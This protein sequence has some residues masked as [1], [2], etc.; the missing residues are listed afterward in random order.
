MTRR[1]ECLEVGC[2]ATVT[3]DDD[4]QLVEAVNAHV[5]EAHSSYE[6]EEIILAAAEDAPE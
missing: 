4:E 2:G 1:W 5:R 6:L 3:A